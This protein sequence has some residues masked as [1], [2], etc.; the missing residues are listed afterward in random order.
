M[1]DMFNE[2]KPTTSYSSDSSDYS[3]SSNNYSSSPSQLPYSID[4]L[5]VISAGGSVFIKEEINA[6][7]IKQFCELIDK[8]SA[9]GYKFVVVIGG[10]KTARAYQE[11]AKKMGA[12]N[13]ELDTIGIN[14][15][16]LNAMLFLNGIKNAYPKVVDKLSELKIIINNYTPIL[17]GMSEG[18]TTDAV[19]ALAAEVLGGKFIN[20][21]NVDGIY[22]ADPRIDSD[23]VLFEKLSFNDVNFLLREK[24]LVP[25]QNLFLDKQAASILTRSKI[26]SAFLSGEHLGDLENY[27]LGNSFRGTI[28]DNI[29]D[30]IEVE[31]PAKMKEIH[32]TFTSVQEND[33][34]QID[35]E[36]D[37]PIDPRKIDFGR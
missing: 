3:S 25:G 24:E 37:E 6:A 28:V 27:L 35:E 32:E 29:S 2:D 21:S 12:N 10:G 20:L 19:A 11:V 4:K 36:D 14:A 30:V 18:Q 5:F 31:T 17:G 23:A 13:F 33:E 1:F 15:T 16:K 22:D 8:F 34:E 7:K 26:P 9:Q